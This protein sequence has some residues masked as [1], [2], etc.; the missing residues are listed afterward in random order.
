MAQW[1]SD[2][3]DRLRAGQPVEGLMR[4]MV[5]DGTERVWMYRNH[6]VTHEA[7]APYVLGHALDITE[8]LREEDVRKRHAAELARTNAALQVEI[9]DRAR[10]EQERDRFF[11]LSVEMLS[12][13]GYDGYF[14]QLNLA[15]EKVLGFS[16]EELM[17]RPIV[18]LVHPD[19][20]AL[21]EMERQRLRLGVA[22]VDFEVRFLTRDGSYRWLWWT[23]VSDK[24]HNYAVARDVIERAGHGERFGHGTG[25]GIGLATHE[26]PSLGKTAP[27]TP[28][29]SPTVFSVEPGIYLEDE[30]GVRIEDLV[31]IDASAGTAR[32]L[33]QF[34]RE[35]VVVGQ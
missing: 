30:T 33:T 8:R 35:V 6:L 13:A 7:S 11:D 31:A 23:G 5:R 27:E 22:V 26:A 34:P 4:L 12:I 29:P 9:D 32:R 3:L 21:T 18:E 2:Y 16:R 24:E 19:D 10:A 14:K 25:H 1:W 28:L 20:R 17:A 15:W